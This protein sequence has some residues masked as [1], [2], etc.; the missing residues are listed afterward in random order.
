MN[1]T[2]IIPAILTD[3]SE[4]FV[5]LVHIFERAKVP[6]VH[7][8]ICD[9][10]FVP[11]TTI[12]GYDELRRLDTPILFDVHLMVTDPE[13]CCQPWGGTRA[14]RIIVHAEAARDFAAMVGHAH[15]CQKQMGAALN[16]DTPLEQLERV[17]GTADFV[18][19][20]T[21]H[22]GAQGRAFVPAVLERIRLFRANHPHMT[23]MADGGITAVTAPQCAA[24]GADVLVSGSAIV[25]DLDPI[26]ALERIRAS[27]QSA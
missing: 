5:R 17:A 10:V 14:S 18:Q 24:A 4:E 11:F 9:G 15:G 12:T 26:A 27:V 1:G 3:S 19:F 20:M 2:Q 21:V 25:R 6:R 22:P 23:I 8:D 7:L 13:N 16:P